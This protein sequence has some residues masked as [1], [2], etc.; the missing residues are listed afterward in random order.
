LIHCHHPYFFTT[1]PTR[2]E[3]IDRL[4]SALKCA[5]SLGGTF[6]AHF[7]TEDEEI[8]AW[9]VWSG[10]PEKVFLATGHDAAEAL[11]RAAIAMMEHPHFAP[12]FEEAVRRRDGD[13][14]G[15]KS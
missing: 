6:E 12:C 9:L 7:Q 15:T 3:I 10:V 8:T 1:A 2:A 11:F 14:L 13:T 4:M 5:Q